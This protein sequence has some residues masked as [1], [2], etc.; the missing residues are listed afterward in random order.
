[1]F[2]RYIA[3]LFIHKYIKYLTAKSIETTE[4]QLKKAREV[5]IKMKEKIEHE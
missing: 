3:F 2:N 5:I 4:Q 1:M